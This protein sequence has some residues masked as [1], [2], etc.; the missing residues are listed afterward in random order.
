MVA[1]G[2]LAS[3]LGD[4]LEPAGT[5]RAQSGLALLDAP[6]GQRAVT[7]C[8]PRLIATTKASNLSQDFSD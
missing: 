4:L 7:P 1:A 6:S 5:K 8:W 2:D 3:L